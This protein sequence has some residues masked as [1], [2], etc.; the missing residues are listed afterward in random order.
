ME[1]EKR[2]N[3]QAATGGTREVR[4]EGCGFAGVSGSETSSGR[5]LKTLCVATPPVSPLRMGA[6]TRSVAR[7][8]SCDQMA[9]RQLERLQVYDV[10]DDVEPDAIHA[11]ASGAVEARCSEDGGE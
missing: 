3:E 4:K 10:A 7:E 5:R 9:R 6:L 1:T 8:R 11:D 2:E